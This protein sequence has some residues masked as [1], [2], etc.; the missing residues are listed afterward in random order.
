MLYPP[1]CKARVQS[2]HQIPEQHIKRDSG[3]AEV[4]GWGWH[5]SLLQQ[6]LLADI[7]TAAHMFL[8]IQHRAHWLDLSAD[9]TAL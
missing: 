4:Q 2:T 6:E 5:G 3:K 1:G 7:S 8:H 9:V